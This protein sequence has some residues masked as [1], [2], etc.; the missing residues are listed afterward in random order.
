MSKDEMRILVV[1]QVRIQHPEY[2]EVQL[3]RAVDEILYIMDY[4]QEVN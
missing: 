2:T 4:A 1:S 3:Q